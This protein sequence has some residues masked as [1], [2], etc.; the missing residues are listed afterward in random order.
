M[1]VSA[2]DRIAVRNMLRDCETHLAATSGQNQY[3][4][5]TWKAAQP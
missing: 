1:H 2:S 3:D 5:T 4:L